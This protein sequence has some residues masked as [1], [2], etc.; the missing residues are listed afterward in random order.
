MGSLN[1]SDP[2]NSHVIRQTFSYSVVDSANGRFKVDGNVVKVL[3]HIQHYDIEN[4]TNLLMFRLKFPTL[5]VW[6]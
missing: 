6:V 2:D 1:T 3:P 4:P 5:G